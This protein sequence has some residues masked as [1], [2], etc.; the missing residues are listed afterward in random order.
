M[1]AIHHTM[2]NLASLLPNGYKELKYI[3]ATGTQWIK[4][5]IIPKNTWDFNLVLSDFIQLEGS[6]K[7]GAIFGVKWDGSNIFLQVTTQISPRE[8][9]QGHWHGMGGEQV[10]DIPVNSDEVS[11]CHYGNGYK[12]CNDAWQ[13]GDR[14]LTK[15]VTTPLCLF[16]IYGMS[17]GI[18]Y[19]R[20][21]LRRFTIREG[22]SQASE[23][24]ILHDLVPCLN[25]E[26][27]PCLYDLMTG[28]EYK[29]ETGVPFLYE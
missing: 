28:K 21:K 12:S 11:S 6:Y 26:K 4:T 15:T 8:D 19:V 14:I 25:K 22:F 16:G 2:A 9:F 29:S 3:Q 1:S 24:I 18:P 5:D 17:S 23:G 7:S 20:V 13:V 10:G 27:V